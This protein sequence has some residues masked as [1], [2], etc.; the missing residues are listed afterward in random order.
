MGK[1]SMSRC[2][3]LNMWSMRIVTE[4]EEGRIYL[5]GVYM[6]K[7]IQVSMGCFGKKGVTKIDNLYSIRAWIDSQCNKPAVWKN[8]HNRQPK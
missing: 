3:G 2:F 8:P 6:R 1:R 4:S 5:D 7:T